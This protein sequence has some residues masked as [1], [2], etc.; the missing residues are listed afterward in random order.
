MIEPKL[1]L[2][3]IILNLTKEM[4]ILKNMK[5]MTTV[6]RYQ[7]FCL[8]LI[9]FNIF[10]TF[11]TIS[12]TDED[13]SCAWYSVYQ[14]ILRYI[15]G[16]NH[17]L[18]WILD[19]IY[20]LSFLMF[21]S[22]GILLVCKKKDRK[23]LIANIFLQTIGILSQIIPYW[24]FGGGLFSK[25]FFYGDTPW[26]KIFFHLSN[27]ILGIFLYRYYKKDPKSIDDSS[28]ESYYLACIICIMSSFAL[29]LL[30]DHIWQNYF[31]PCR[32]LDEY[33]DYASRCIMRYIYSIT[34]S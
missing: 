27:L 8:N 12:K 25:Y 1:T 24:K 33:E 15:F 14:D 3:Y 32:Y 22:T 19:W 10:A 11:F 21:L 2:H 5:K 31:D 13:F 28:F 9:F 20:D 18:S 6:K 7:I 16:P 29:G 34:E 4:I 17:G 23:F 26:M 30:Y